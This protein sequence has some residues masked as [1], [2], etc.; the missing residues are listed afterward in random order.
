MLAHNIWCYKGGLNFHVLKKKN[1]YSR[2]WEKRL[3]K[4]WHT[5][6]IL[7]NLANRN[8]CFP[9]SFSFEKRTKEKNQIK[10]IQKKVKKKWEKNSNKESREEKSLKNLWKNW[11]EVRKNS[12]KSEK[13]KKKSRIFQQRSQQKWS[14]IYLQQ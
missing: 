5:S 8:T 6:I 12:S 11:K 2:Y 13:L 3:N 9:F 10:K 7:W 4:D 14:I 1:C